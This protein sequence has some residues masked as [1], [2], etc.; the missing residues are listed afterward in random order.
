M[1]RLLWI[2]PFVLLTAS[3]A[4]G[5]EASPAVELPPVDVKPVRVKVYTLGR[6]VTAPELLPSNQTPILDEKCKNKEDRT[7]LVSTFI[8]TTGVPCGVRLPHSGYSEV[9]EMA[10]NIV[11]DDRFK[12]GTYSGTPVVVAENVEVNLPLCLET[13]T[14]SSGKM[15]TQARLRAQPKQKFVK[16][17][18]PPEEVVLSPGAVIPPVQINFVPAEFSEEARKAKFQGTVLISIIVD[19]QGM[20]Q[21]PRVIR[22]AG[23]GLDEK[24]LE[25]V[26]KYRFKPAMKNGKPVAAPSNIEIN[27]RL[28]DRS[29]NINSKY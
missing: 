27:F 8:D 9:S 25:A 16:F 26:M 15:T 24:A 23:M 5:Q 10:L 2:A 7:I 17:E 1:R 6:G 29:P 22:A 3:C 21:N 28:Y 13:K 11:I 12:P 14:D 19:A 20:P 18:N 4:I